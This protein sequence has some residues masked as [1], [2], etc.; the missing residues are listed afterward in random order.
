M[1]DYRLAPEHPFPAALIDSR[2]ALEWVARNGPAGARPAKSLALAGDSAGANLAAA[3]C[4]AAIQD[5]TTVP[6]RLALIGPALDA[7]H[8]P[9]RVG[10]RDSIVTPE[11]IAGAFETY[12]AGAVDPADPRVSPL[13]TKDD[14]LAKFPPTLIQVSGAEG[15]I[16]DAR[17]FAQRLEEVE[18]RVLLSIWPRMPHVWHVFLT[19]LPEASEAIRE[20]GWFIDPQIDR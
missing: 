11:S 3:V 12:I 7:V 4:A 19:A 15:W 8:D 18:V 6:N 17:A 13:R 2:A 9:L 20:I 5:S 1:A 16:F 10:R 14:V